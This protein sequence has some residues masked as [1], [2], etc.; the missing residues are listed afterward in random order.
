M[1][2]WNNLPTFNTDGAIA[3][4]AE[5]APPA[6]A[7]DPSPAPAPAAPS[8]NSETPVHIDETEKW[9][10]DNFEPM[11]EDFDDVVEVPPQE[12]AAPTSQPVPAA[13]SPVQSAETPAPTAPTATEPQ[14]A[15]TTPTAPVVAAAP[16]PVAPSAP[17]PSQQA[18]PAGGEPTL[19]LS[20]IAEELDKQQAK[21]VEALAG[22]QYKL[23]DEDINNF[24]EKPGEVIAKVAAQVQVATTKSVMKVFAEQLPVVVNGL[25]QARTQ[26]Q[27]AEDSF[28]SANPGL[29]RT[30]HKDLVLQV[31]RNVRQMNPQMPAD[32]FIKMVGA[33]S[34]GMAGVQ[35]AA[36]PRQNGA[37][38]GVNRLQPQAQ[39]STPGPVVR[40]TG[41]AF[42]P[43]GAMGAPPSAH[44]APQLSG[45]E[46]LTELYL[47]DER[48]E[49]DR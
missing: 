12:V 11:N 19:S 2:L 46:A 1:K 31:S 42:V 36:P 24:M 3:A 25:I 39:V 32:Q 7:P 15:V 8:L 17:Q 29:D 10:L 22:S 14:P 26:H 5:A 18:P 21:F 4:G 23:S 33:I 35:N 38:P 6:A 28:W 47:A 27:Q 40:Q 44:P 41:G 9:V 48:G 16:P 20:Q 45:W 34:A 37:A 49:F 43:G 30:K 13:Q